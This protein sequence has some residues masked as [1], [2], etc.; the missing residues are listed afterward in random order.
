MN[1][2]KSTRIVIVIVFLLC[3]AVLGYLIISEVS[4]I[5]KTKKTIEE[6]E[7]QLLSKRTI[8]MR[9]REI[10]EN[11]HSL[12]DRYK[13]I[14]GLIPNSLSE[15]S[16]VI[17]IQNYAADASVTMLSVTFDPGIKKGD[18]I[19]MPLNMSFKGTYK[20]FLSLLSNILY[21]ERLIKID[22]IHIKKEND[23]LFI[24]LTA[25]AFCA[26]K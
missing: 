13:T 9:S 23:G 6:M 4:G 8:L 24:D 19:E 3:T 1:V 21:G 15:E 11:I 18:L 14:S 20:G 17:E 7:H 10:K 16:I 25:K 26:G 5:Q 2:S 12:E 22:S